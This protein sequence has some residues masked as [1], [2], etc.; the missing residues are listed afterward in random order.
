[1]AGGSGGGGAVDGGS[2]AG[3]DVGCGFRSDGG[4]AW[5]PLSVFMPAGS[6][7]LTAALSDAGLVVAGDFAEGGHDELLVTV[8]GPSQVLLVRLRDQ[9]ALVLEHAGTFSLP[10]AP[11]R[12]ERFRNEP[13]ARDGVM[14]WTADGGFALL[15][16]PARLGF[17][18]LGRWGGTDMAVLDANA[19]GG[20]ELLH[21]DDGGFISVF[22][23]PGLDSGPRSLSGTMRLTAASAGPNAFWAAYDESSGPRLQTF[24]SPGFVDGGTANGTFS[25]GGTPSEIL[26]RPLALA[27][28]FGDRPFL[29]ATF[30]DA[31]I[32]GQLRL[33]DLTTPVLLR[34]LSA[35]IDPPLEVAT[36]AA[37]VGSWRGDTIGSVCVSDVAGIKR[38]QLA[39]ALDGGF[40]TALTNL[41]IGPGA[42]LSSG[43]LGP[44]AGESLVVASGVDGGA[45]FVLPGDPR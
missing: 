39:R 13:G 10:V 14:V 3:V 9:G 42:T 5:C 44:D 4:L 25:Q 35:F 29:V 41:I 18:V 23:P 22:R 33:W 1:M 38:W 43:I 20:D 34:D 11:A 2:D 27:A 17:M 8:G 36:T 16:A 6:G 7:F 37:V 12:L 45:L 15:S 30:A 19:D 28:G 26:E 40:S 32:R 24:V 21:A 31:G